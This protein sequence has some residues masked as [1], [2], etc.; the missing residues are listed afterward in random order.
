MITDSVQVLRDG[1]GKPIFKQSG[2]GFMLGG[3]GF[4][5]PKRPVDPL[6]SMPKP[7]GSPDKTVDLQTDHRQAM[8]FRLSGDY[9]RGLD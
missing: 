4:G 1:N 7:S 3:G 6:D 8:I 2:C 5:G 9:N